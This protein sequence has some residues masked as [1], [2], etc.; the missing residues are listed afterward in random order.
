MP[1]PSRVNPL[2]QDYL[3]LKGLCSTCGSGFTREEALTAPANPG[4]SGFLDN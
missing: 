4:L 3:Q 2:P 1:A